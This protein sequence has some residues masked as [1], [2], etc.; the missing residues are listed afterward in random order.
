MLPG[1]WF[2]LISLCLSLE[3]YSHVISLLYS[4]DNGAFVKNLIMQCSCLFCSVCVIDLNIHPLPG[5]TRRRRHTH[6]S[7]S[8]T[9][10]I[11]SLTACMFLGCERKL[12]KN[13]RKSMCTWEELA[14]STQKDL[15]S[16]RDSNW[17]P[18]SFEVTALFTSSLCH[19]VVENVLVCLSWKVKKRNKKRHLV[20]I[21]CREGVTL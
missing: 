14:N 13:W 7:H 16:D 4:Y 3:D 15:W 8:H 9:G 20:F 10:T 18:S 21:P 5:N 19:A 17:G 6:H 1:Q 11:Q 2:Q 12:E